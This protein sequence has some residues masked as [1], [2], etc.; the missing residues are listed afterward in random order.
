MEHLRPSRWHISVVTPCYN[1]AGNV[2]VLYERVRPVVPSWATVL[3]QYMDNARRRHRIDRGGGQRR[4][5]KVLSI[6]NLAISA[7]PTTRSFNAAEMQSS[8]WRPTCR[9]AG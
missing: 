4:N 9:S 7:R 1:E 5:V 3:R 2:D 6:R 8:E